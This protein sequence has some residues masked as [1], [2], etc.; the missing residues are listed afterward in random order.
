MFV[1][2]IATSYTP[3]Y[4]HSFVANN[5]W[6]WT[7][8]L[9]T[10]INVVIMICHGKRTWCVM[11]TKLFALGR[12]YLVDKQFVRCYANKENDTYLSFIVGSFALFFFV[13]SLDALCCILRSNDSWCAQRWLPSRMCSLSINCVE[14]WSD[15]CI[16][17]IRGLIDDFVLELSMINILRSW[18]ALFE[19]VE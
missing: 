16:E 17:V 10:S 19:F 3:T 2:T 8:A 15:C 5:V 9:E 6:L 12:W 14:T 11:K 7:S 1:Y 13:L 4:G 18:F